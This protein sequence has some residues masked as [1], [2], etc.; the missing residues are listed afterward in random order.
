[1]YTW[2]VQNL[3]HANIYGYILGKYILNLNYIYFKFKL[4][5]F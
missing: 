4:Y 1:M 5:I 3:S 2:N